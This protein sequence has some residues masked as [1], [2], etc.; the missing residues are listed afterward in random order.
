MLRN[1]LGEKRCLENTEVQFHTNI[2]CKVAGALNPL[3][4][5]FHPGSAQDLTMH[6]GGRKTIS[7]TSPRTPKTSFRP[8]YSATGNTVG[9]VLFRCI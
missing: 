4:P 9:L 3:V 6:L 2:Y 5:V 7:R 8:L 1:Q